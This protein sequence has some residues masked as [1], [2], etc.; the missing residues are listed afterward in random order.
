MTALKMSVKFRIK[1]KIPFSIEKLS[2]TQFRCGVCGK[3]FFSR[4]KLDNH[5]LDEKYNSNTDLQFPEIEKN[6]DIRV[7]YTKDIKD[8]TNPKYPRLKKGDKIFLDK[9]NKK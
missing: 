3:I 5:L 8:L 2:G 4:E 7:I 9:I 1:N 6:L